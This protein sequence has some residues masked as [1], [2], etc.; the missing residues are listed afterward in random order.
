MKKIKKLF[1]Y[2]AK[3]TFLIIDILISIEIILIS[4]VNINNL[5]IKNALFLI[6]VL[7]IFIRNFVNNSMKEMIINNN[8]IKYGNENFLCLFLN[9]ISLISINFYVY[10]NFSDNYF[11]MYLLI[12]TLSL[13]LIILNVKNYKHIY[14]TKKIDYDVKVNLNSL[15]PKPNYE[16]YKNSVGALIQGCENSRNNNIA[17]DGKYGSGKSSI[18]ET[19]INEIGDEYAYLKVSFAKFNNAKIEQDKLMDQIYQEILIHDIKMPNYFLSG[20]ITS[21]LF[22]IFILLNIFKTFIVFDSFTNLLCSIC[23]TSI[24]Y[25]ITIFIVNLKKGKIG[26]GDSSLEL[27][28]N[29]NEIDANKLKLLKL[30]NKFNKTTIIFIED[31]DRFNDITI[32]QNFRELNFLLN[33]KL[34]NRVIF[35]YALDTSIF[36]STEERT[37]F[38]DLI[39]PVIPIGVKSDAMSYFCTEIVEEIEQKL[40]LVCSSFSNNLRILNNVQ[41]EYILIKKQFLEFNNEY[42]C[43]EKNKIFAMVMFKNF[44][45]RQYVELFEYNN[46][47]D[48]ILKDLVNIRYDDELKNTSLFTEQAKMYLS[49]VNLISKTTLNSKR[50]SYKDFVTTI[51]KFVY[52]Q[53]EEANGIYPR[54]YTM[55]KDENEKRKLKDF[56][57]ELITIGVLDFDYFE[58]LIPIA[59]NSKVYKGR[60]KEYFNDL[61]QRNYIIKNSNKTNLDYNFCDLYDVVR[62]LPETCFT[63]NSIHNYNIIHLIFEESFFTT[64]KECYIKSFLYKVDKDN[65]N[66]KKLLFKTIDKYMEKNNDPDLTILNYYKEKK[67]IFELF[68]MEDDD[69]IYL[70]KFIKIM[71]NNNEYINLK[72]TYS[73]SINDNINVKT[74]VV[75]NYEDFYEYLNYDFD[76]YFLERLGKSLNFSRKNLNLNKALVQTELFNDD[77]SSY[78]NLCYFLDDNASE[79]LNCIEGKLEKILD[80]LEEN[81]VGIKKYN[82]KINRL[83]RNITSCNY[84]FYENQSILKKLSNYSNYSNFYVSYESKPLINKLKFND[85][86]DITIPIESINILID[87]SK[88]PY[89]KLWLDYIKEKNHSNELINSR[90]Y[91]YISDNFD[92]IFEEGLYKTY[93]T[94]EQMNQYI[95][96]NVVDVKKIAT[97]YEEFQ[98]DLKN[99]T[100]NLK[101]NSLNYAY[102]CDKKFDKVPIRYL[103]ECTDEVLL[104]KFNSCSERDYYIEKFKSTDGATSESTSTKYNH[105][106]KIMLQNKDVA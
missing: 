43:K 57:L 47:F 82:Y 29:E 37:K 66:L 19:F 25:I 101:I 5:K 105:F 65:I 9:C 78:E 56:I 24:F 31:L 74:K 93:F 61:E 87:C 84:D 50:L 75:N 97:I 59:F 49:T 102:D 60:E 106:V 27:E 44:Y 48:E 51:D 58:Y 79:N 20:L 73:K 1:N 95:R 68:T 3:R 71:L 80:F 46:F 76:K 8:L 90:Y 40:L 85:I 2:L 14:K 104:N 52:W 83:F 32:F 35:I 23:F 53:K 13:I 6:S 16:Y 4:F 77:M 100:D 98:I 45:P 94:N 92:S 88:L 91:K 64:K 7:Y 86:N 55:V 38:F 42:Y 30:L 70:S 12:S 96:E 39:I 103:F 22:S 33:E 28:K 26:I 41:N 69:V 11:W 89:S 36:D 99:N 72:D 21:L 62:S 10:I 81:K 54:K 15:A 17:L 63:Y 18:I 67:E 34:L